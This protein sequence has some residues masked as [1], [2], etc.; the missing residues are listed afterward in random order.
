MEGEIEGDFIA[1]V[2]WI[3]GGHST[4]R[5]ADASAAQSALRQMLAYARA[6]GQRVERARVVPLDV[7]IDEVRLSA[8]MGGRRILGL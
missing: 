4:V 1:Q 2:V 8:T 6:S 5:S 3:S 7:F